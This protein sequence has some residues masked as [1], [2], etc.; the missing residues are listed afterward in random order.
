MK[1]KAAKIW[2]DAV[3]S[4]RKAQASLETGDDSSAILQCKNALCSACVAITLGEFGDTGWTV[5]R[6]DSLNTLGS[7]QAIAETHKILQMLRQMAPPEDP[8]P[9]VQL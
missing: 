8:F 6:I 5:A 4:F 1:P 2:E 3:V 7:T 9:E